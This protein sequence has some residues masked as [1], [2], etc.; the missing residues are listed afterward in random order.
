MYT[1]I[2]TYSTY[3][4]KDIESLVLVGMAIENQYVSGYICKL[5]CFPLVARGSDPHAKYGHHVMA[6]QREIDTKT[7]DFW[8]QCFQRDLF[9]I[10]RLAKRRGPSTH[11]NTGEYFC[12]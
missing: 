1:C 7:W 4:Q 9:R 12:T 8:V 6:S 10:S 3:L 2:F 5:I 11:Q